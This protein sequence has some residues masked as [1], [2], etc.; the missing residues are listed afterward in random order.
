MDLD[1][2]HLGYSSLLPTIGNVS[3]SALR[4]RLPRTDADKEYAMRIP[5]SF[6]RMFVGLI[7]CDGYISITK[8]H[9]KDNISLCLVLAVEG[10]D[11]KMLEYLKSVLQ[12]GV[13]K[14]YPA[15]NTA[16]YIIN[17]T[18]LQEIIFPLPLWSSFRRQEE[19]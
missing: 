9:K 4:G 12:V 7:D 8:A 10:R 13:I 18:D 11:M 17:R 6:L 1:L 3:V 2:S 15:T 14:Y 5:Y 19:G 16:K